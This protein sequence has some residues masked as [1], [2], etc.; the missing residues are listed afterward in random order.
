MRLVLDTNVYILGFFDLSN[1]GNSSE[2]LILKD[3]MLKEKTLLLSKFIEDQILGVALR[4]K[5]KDFAGLLKFAIW[6]SFSIDFVNISKTK[7]YLEKIPRKDVDI[8][9]TALEGNA[10]FLI[11][12]D[13]DFR[14]KASMCQSKFKCLT[15][16]EFVKV[17]EN[18]NV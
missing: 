10:D 18:S 7:E 15:P 12:N 11:T 14:K 9:L 17:L 6:T 3:L 5:G 2:S 1:G 16:D 4:K 13:E 8:F